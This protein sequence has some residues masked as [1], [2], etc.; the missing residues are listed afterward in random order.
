MYYKNNGNIGKVTSG[1]LDEKSPELQSA[2]LIDGMAHRYGLL[3][4][5]VIQRATTQ[6]LYIYDA[7]SSYQQYIHTKE[8]KKNN[9][10]NEPAE[11]D[12]NLVKQMEQWRAN[13]G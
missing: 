1:Q 4:S 7:V 13:R 6:D 2:V 10:L 8:R 5:E 9:I 12:A 11:A 3:P